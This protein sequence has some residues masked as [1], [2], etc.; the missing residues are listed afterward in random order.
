MTSKWPEEVA[1]HQR[2]LK[3]GMKKSHQL[4]E[5]VADT[6]GAG[7]GHNLSN[8]WKTY[9]NFDYFAIGSLKYT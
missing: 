4:L 5:P 8:I 1:R 7:R 3:V 2:G 9:V 6:E